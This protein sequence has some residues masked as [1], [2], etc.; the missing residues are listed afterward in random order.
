MAYTHRLRIQLAMTID[1]GTVDSA[2]AILAEVFDLSSVRIAGDNLPPEL[3]IPSLLLV[4][5]LS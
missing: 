3:P 2:S 1:D 4:N 5:L